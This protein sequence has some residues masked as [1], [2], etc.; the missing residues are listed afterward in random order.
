MYYSTID[1]SGFFD[2]YTSNPSAYGQ[3]IVGEIVNNKAEA[4]CT[5]VH[6][7]L[8]L[9]VI[10]KHLSGALSIGAAP[11]LPNNTVKWC[12]IDIDNYI[13]NLQDIVEAI[14]DFNL[15]L[16]PCY[17]KSKKLHIYCFFSEETDADEAQKL[18][19]WYLTA[20]RCDPKTEIFPKQSRM[21]S[22]SRFPSWINL[23]YFQASDEHNHRKGLHRDMTPMTLPEFVSSARDKSL[24]IKE[25]WKLLEE[26]EYFEAPPCVLSGVILRDV[27]PGIR[28]QWLYNVACYLRMDDEDTDIVEPLLA[29]NDT[30]HTPLPEREIESTVA[31]VASR[32]Y[33]YQCAG[34]VGCNKQGCKNTEKGVG[35]NSSTKFSFGQLTKILTD[36]IAW[37]W[38]VNGKLLRFSDTQMIM[39]QNEFRKQCMEKIN[40]MPYKVKE[41]KWT[42]ILRRA[43]ENVVEQQVEIEGNFGSG[44]IFLDAVTRYFQGA[45]RRATTTDQVLAF[46]KVY[47]DE[48]A[49]RFLFSSNNFRLFL[50]E[51]EGLK[52]DDG[53]IRIRLSEL[54]AQQVRGGM[55]SIPIESIGTDTT[56]SA[57]IDYH[58]TT[59]ED[60]L[61]F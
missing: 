21:S 33:F 54:G 60:S 1:A 13:G 7:P 16:V 19:R 36:P 34:M 43:L 49:K 50:T 51:H 40:D 17:S 3:T 38:E 20:F 24:T 32:S 48:E 22:N 15:P 29:L 4:K 8:T 14:Y 10:N 9:A 35:S 42:T 53:Q 5:L 39:N 45:R 30:L 27:P 47:K 41:E 37:E 23:P 28:N 25:H 57:T 61:G 59:T 31:K 58:D 2:L 18:L 11:L 44:S 26:L 12:A 56:I 55:W 6:S 52:I 46:G